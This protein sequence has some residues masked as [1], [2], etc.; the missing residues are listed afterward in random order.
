LTPS[1]TDIIVK[2]LVEVLSVFSLATKQIKQGRLSECILADNYALTQ[3]ASEKFANRLLRERE[4]EAVLERLDRLTEEEARMTVVQTLELVH[5]L[6][7]NIKIV[8]DSE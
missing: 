6:V 4:I 2:I 5:V 1:I 3:I 7:N 8:M